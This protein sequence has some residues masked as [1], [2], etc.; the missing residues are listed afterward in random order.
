MI[1]LHKLKSFRAPQI[2]I[3][4]QNK[5]PLEDPGC[6]IST[7]VKKTTVA[8]TGIRDLISAMKAGAGNTAKGQNWQDY[9]DDN[10]IM[11]GIYLDIDT[12]ATGFS[13]TPIYV[14]AIVGDAWHYATTG[15]SAIYSPTATSFRVYVR[16]SSNDV[17]PN[18]PNP[19]DSISNE[20]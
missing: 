3:M 9:I 10:G 4:E 15:G 13:D 1:V 19:P 11:R 6:D 12:S 14:S 7:I 20:I 5:R 8:A 16:W 2:L 18:P 17:G